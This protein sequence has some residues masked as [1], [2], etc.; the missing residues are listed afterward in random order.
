[1]PNLG[2]GIVCEPNSCKPLLN[3]SISSVYQEHGV[4]NIDDTIWFKKLPIGSLVRILPNHS[5][6]TCAGYE[7][8][9]V[10]QN[11]EIQ[12]TGSRTNGW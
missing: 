3:L 1:M 5:C 9:N 12:N 6:I 7:N 2:Y 10:I 8:Y 4:I 11:N